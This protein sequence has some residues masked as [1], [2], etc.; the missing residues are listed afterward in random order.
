LYEGKK[1]MK[2]ERANWRKDGTL[3]KYNAIEKIKIK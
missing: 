3:K 1:K 2:W